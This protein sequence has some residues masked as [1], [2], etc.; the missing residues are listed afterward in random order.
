MPASFCSLSRTP[1][2]PHEEKNAVSAVPPPA[3][4]D[5][6]LHLL[7]IFPGPVH[8]LPDYFQRRLEGLSVIA[9][10][11]VVLNGDREETA[12]FGTFDVQVSADGSG[13]RFRSWLARLPK[14]VALARRQQAA[15]D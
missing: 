13:G 4:P 8:H 15:G 9:R 1:S 11:T 12:H 6:R 7:L 2:S 3:A 14:T 10:G 5:N